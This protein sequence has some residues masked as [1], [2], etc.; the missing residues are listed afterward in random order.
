M[1]TWGN[2]C[3]ACEL[4]S[5]EYEG[6]ETVKYGPSMLTEWCQD[7]CKDCL[8]AKLLELGESWSYKY[9]AIGGDTWTICKVGK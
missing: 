7:I 9:R 3:Q 2:W 6:R 1:G 5:V 8:D 4:G